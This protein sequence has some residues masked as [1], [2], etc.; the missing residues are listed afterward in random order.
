MAFLIIGGSTGSGKSDIAVACA[1]R[2]NGEIV[3]ADSMQIYRGLDIGTAKITRAEMQG[4]PHHMIDI[5][6]PSDSFTAADYKVRASK[7]AEDILSRGKLPIFCGGTGL[8][9]NA[10][11]YDLSFSGEFD[12]KLR[13]ELLKESAEKG[14]AF[15]HEK[16]RSLDP[17]AA[18]RLHVNDEKRVIR[19]I[20]KALTGGKKE[21]DF[22]SPKYPYKM[23]VTDLPRETL[24]R[25]IDA[26]VDK[27]MA[28]GLREEVER[29]LRQGIGYDKQCMQAI[30]YKEWAK[31]SEGMTETEVVELIKKNTRN[32]AKR[33]VTWF[34]QYQDAIRISVEGRS[35]EEIAREIA[36]KY[37]EDSNENTRRS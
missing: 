17:E 14:K 30:A 12:P 6:E 7:A 8:Y 18:A 5:C 10:V 4:I 22:L 33:Q 26:R 20:E 36:E 28:S 19:A 37:M 34:K 29:L 13:K 31:L 16:L 23:F 11:L 25:R 1:K 32:Y 21:A 27:M 2:M 15:M 24:Y 3:S 9:L 35:A